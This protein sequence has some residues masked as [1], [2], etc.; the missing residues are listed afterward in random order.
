MT[1]QPHARSPSVARSIALVLA[2]VA[3]LA[4]GCGDDAGTSTATTS[5]GATSTTGGDASGPLVTYHR[6]GGFA[7]VDDMLSVSAEGEATLE[8]GALGSP[9][10]HS[11]FALSSGELDRVTGAV[12][13]ADISGST[14]SPAACADCFIYTLETVSGR[15]RFT[16]VDVSQGDDATVRPEVFDLLDVLSGIVEQHAPAAGGSTPAR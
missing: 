11:E 4:T 15:T 16:D 6:S 8:T 9:R 3:C 12:E 2:L 5:T 1:E 10:K 14:E 13:A 7:P